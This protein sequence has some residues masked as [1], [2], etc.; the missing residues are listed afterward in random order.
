MNRNKDIYYFQFH[1]CFPQI[2][3]FDV[4]N[5]PQTIREIL[6]VKLSVFVEISFGTK[7][8]PFLVPKLICRPN[9]CPPFG[10]QA[11]VT[12]SL[13]SPMWIQKQVVIFQ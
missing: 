9:L 4:V 10:H 2:I 3:S 5:F 11:E 7:V 13:I 1:S 8:F 12:I 6:K